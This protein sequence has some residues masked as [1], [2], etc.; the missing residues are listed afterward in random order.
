MK[1]KKKTIDTLGK[2]LHVLA[3]IARVCTYIGVFFM[4]LVMVIV[5]IIFSKIEINKNY[6]DIKGI[7]DTRIRIYKD[8]E[9]KLSVKV[10]DK[11]TDLSKDVDNQEAIVLLSSLYDKTTNT[12]TGAIVAYIEAYFVFCIVSMILT[13]LALKYFGKFCKSIF[14]NETLFT[15]DKPK[16]LKKVGILMIIAYA[17]SMLLGGALSGVLGGNFDFNLNSVGI[18][19]I[20]VIF[21]ATYIFEYGTLLEAK[22]VEEPKPKKTTKK[23]TEEK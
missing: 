6:I 10:N 16:Y 9:G 4:V 1:E 14:E 11:V 23:K 13:A 18:V 21:L 3:I 15:D 8:L 17:V 22:P 12:T 2:V 7:P 19:E 20:L 5:P